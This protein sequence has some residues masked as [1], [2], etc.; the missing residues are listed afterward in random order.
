MCTALEA[1]LEEN[2]GA[3]VQELEVQKHKRI[4]VGCQS[5]FRSVRK[6]IPHLIA[7]PNMEIW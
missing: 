4:V 5:F 1:G 7:L 2:S 3:H 6:V